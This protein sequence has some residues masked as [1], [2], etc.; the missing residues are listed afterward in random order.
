MRILFRG[1]VIVTLSYSAK[2]GKPL[3][4]VLSEEEPE[5]RLNA[6]GSKPSTTGI[7]THKRNL[8]PLSKT[9]IWET[10]NHYH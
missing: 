6:D 1:V 4:S 9:A 3:A 8:K 7:R 5:V 2:K 10:G